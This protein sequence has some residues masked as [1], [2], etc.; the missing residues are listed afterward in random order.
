MGDSVDFTTLKMTPVLWATPSCELTLFGFS[1]TQNRKLQSVELTCWMQ[2]WRISSMHAPHPYSLP[3]LSLSAPFLSVCLV[4]CLPAAGPTQRPKESPGETYR[5]HEMLQKHVVIL[6]F[7]SMHYV[8]R[9]K[10]LASCSGLF[11]S[12]TRLLFNRISQAAECILNDLIRLNLN[13][14]DCYILEDICWYFC[15]LIN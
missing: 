6:K 5:V 13:Y 9:F 11:G 4:P 2:D 10:T 14:S 12:N 15:E 3:S 7:V 8:Q 1:L